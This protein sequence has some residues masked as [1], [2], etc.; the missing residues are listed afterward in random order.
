MLNHTV[1]YM[2]TLSRAYM[3]DCLSVN[4]FYNKE[5]F[6]FGLEIVKSTINYLNLTFIFYCLINECLDRTLICSILSI[7][8]LFLHNYLTNDKVS[9]HIRRPR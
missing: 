7:T 4:I 2:R 8:C 3:H 5:F 6:F 1:E 9:R